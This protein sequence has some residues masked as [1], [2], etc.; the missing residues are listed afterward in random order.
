MRFP[1][2]ALIAPLITSVVLWLVTGSAYTL[3]FALLG[4]VMAV[5]QFFDGTFHAK[6]EARKQAERE[7]EDALAHSQQDQLESFA[8]Q[9]TRLTQSNE[10]RFEQLR[11]GGKVNPLDLRV[12]KT[13]FQN[14]CQN[15]SLFQLADQFYFG[16]EEFEFQ[17]KVANFVVFA[18]KGFFPANLHLLCQLKQ[19]SKIE[20]IQFDVCRNDL[21]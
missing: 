12:G 13:L 2:F 7:D 9:L 4:P 21:L 8:L 10:Q 6:R 14:L 18:A 1:V 11:P 15:L 20:N 17:P 16:T 3:L 19:I 5:A